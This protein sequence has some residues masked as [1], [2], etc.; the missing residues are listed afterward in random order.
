MKNIYNLDSYFDSIKYHIYFFDVQIK[1]SSVT[2][3]ALLH[4]LDIVNVPIPYEVDIIGSVILNCI[5]C[6][7]LTDDVSVFAAKVFQS[8]LSIR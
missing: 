4:D 6:P 3:E 1:K 5:F 7:F 2:K 8:P